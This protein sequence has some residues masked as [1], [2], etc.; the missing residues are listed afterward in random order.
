L[1]FVIFALIVIHIFFLHFEGS[2]N[3]LGFSE[4]LD[5]VPFH[6][7]YTIKD[8]MGFFL[9]FIV[10]SWLIFFYPWALGEPDNFIPANPLVTP[11]HIKPEWYFLWAYAVLRSIPNKLGGVLIIF[12]AVLV[13]FLPPFLVKQEKKGRQYYILRQVVFWQFIIVIFLLTKLGGLPV[14]GAV[15]IIGQIFSVLFFLIFF[16]YIYRGAIE[17]LLLKA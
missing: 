3:P 13:I 14:R 2:S 11:L 7:Y 4:T 12:A 8:V 9:F 16:L 15:E 10:R 1:P 6:I 5:K 17:D